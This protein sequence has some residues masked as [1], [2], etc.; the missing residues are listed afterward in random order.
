MYSTA[1]CP[2]C[3]QARRLLD[4]KSVVYQDI[5]VDRDPAL[6]QKMTQLSG[7][8]TVPQIWIGDHHVG[9]FIDLWELERRGTL[10]QLLAQD[11]SAAGQSPA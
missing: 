8:R 10:D 2:Y 9:G 4:D 1:W 6:R 5:A 3:I 11:A 7:R